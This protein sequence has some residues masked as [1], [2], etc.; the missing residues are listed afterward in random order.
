[1]IIGKEYTF[2]A[3]HWL[4]QEGNDSRESRNHGHTFIADIR[5]DISVIRGQTSEA[6]KDIED[7]IQHLIEI[8]DHSELNNFIP[9]PS[10]ENTC[11]YMFETLF[12]WIPDL[13]GIV[14]RESGGGY[15]SYSFNDY[16]IQ[17]R[18]F[19]EETERREERELEILDDLTKILACPAIR[20]IKREFDDGTMY[21]HG[22]PENS[23]ECTCGFGGHYEDQ[24]GNI[25]KSSL[26]TPLD[27]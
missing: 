16:Q 20:T 23:E 19:E 14:L 27:G 7:S 12:Q 9:N 1:M 24:E 2:H 22:L 11:K 26:D 25:F 21:D 13:A 4:D 6:K 15:V 17:K 18:V 5:I 3:A 8:L 10:L